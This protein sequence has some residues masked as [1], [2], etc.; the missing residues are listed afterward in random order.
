MLNS[1]FEK[2]PDSSLDVIKKK[3]MLQG[4]DG[5]ADFDVSWRLLSGKIS[6]RE[7]RLLLSEAVAIF[8]VC[9]FS[10]FK[11]VMMLISNA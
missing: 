11:L 4:S 10:F 8:H 1:G 7:T 2:L 3:H 5:A 6:S 9:T